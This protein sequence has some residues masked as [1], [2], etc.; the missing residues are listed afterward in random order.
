MENTYP[1][2]WGAKP[3]CKKPLDTDTRITVP[4]VGAATLRWEDPKAVRK[5][6][7]IGKGTSKNDGGSSIVWALAWVQSII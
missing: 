6:F 2:I 7:R 3:L 4:W 1:P 5:E